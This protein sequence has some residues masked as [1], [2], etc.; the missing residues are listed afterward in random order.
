MRQ[1]GNEHLRQGRFAG[2]SK[3][4]VE[5]AHAIAAADFLI[6]LRPPG[7]EA[8]AALAGARG[9]AMAGAIPFLAA[10]HLVWAGVLLGAMIAQGQPAG[11]VP[12]PLIALL[13][14][15]FLLWGL[16]RRTGGRPLLYPGLPVARMN[17]F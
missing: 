6:D 1:N 13:A 17:G 10:A 3:A 12:L 8:E 2:L 16:V 4:G 7:D 9:A 14:S 5:P 15:D 11:V